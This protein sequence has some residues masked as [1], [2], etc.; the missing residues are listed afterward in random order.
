[1][2]NNIKIFIFYIFLLINCI[3]CNNNI[4]NNNQITHKK[5]YG[6]NISK[7]NIG[8]DFLLN[9]TINK[10]ISLKN[11]NN[12]VNIL[13]FGYTH[14][15]DICPTYLFNYAKAI[16][17]LKGKSNK[18]QLYFITLDHNRDK[19][20]ILN[21]Y[22]KYFNKEFIGLIPDN[23]Q[24]KEIKKNWKIISYKT[25]QSNNYFINHSSG[26]YILVNSKAILYEPHN[27]TYKQLYHDIKLLIANYL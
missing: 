5:F 1:M 7:D 14:C 16:K 19:K 15:P 10:K 23:K 11:S 8:K 26:A 18:V 12:K 24:L 4:K 17:L 21:S 3:S 25:N 9:S 20:E 22:L 27:I 13:L 2:Y 6:T